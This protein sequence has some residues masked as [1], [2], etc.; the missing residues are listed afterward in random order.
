M[1]YVLKSSCIINPKQIRPVYY[2]Q[3]GKIKLVTA[4]KGRY[5]IYVH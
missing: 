5:T 1:L 4:A 2:S 3:T